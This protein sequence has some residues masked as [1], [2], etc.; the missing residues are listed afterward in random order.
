MVSHVII[1]RFRARASTRLY[2]EFTNPKSTIPQKAAREHFWLL[3]LKRPCS[4]VAP[5][6]LTSGKD[7]GLQDIKEKAKHYRKKGGRQDGAA[8]AGPAFA[9]A[10]GTGDSSLTSSLPSFSARDLTT[11]GSG[12]G[13]IFLGLEISGQYINR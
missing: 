7:R 2:F 3:C 6:S 11:S 4:Y 1:N 8:V 13:L 10:S 9:D 12:T 5:V